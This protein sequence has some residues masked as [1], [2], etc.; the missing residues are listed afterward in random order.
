VARF[1]PRLPYPRRRC[2]SS[3]HA[4]R[5]RGAGTP[6]TPRRRDRP[7]AFG[8]RERARPRGGTSSRCRG[9]VALPVARAGPR[10]VRTRH[11]A[12]ARRRPA[13][14]RASPARRS[15]RRRHSRRFVLVQQ[16]ETHVRYA[17][18]SDGPICS[19]IPGVVVLDT[20]QVLDTPREPDRA[21]A[22]A[23]LEHSVPGA[24]HRVE[25]PDGISCQPRIFGCEALLNQDPEA[26]GDVSWRYVSEW[27]Q[28]RLRCPAEPL[29]PSRRS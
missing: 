10:L 28:S 15:S 27:S 25:E 11:E 3:R 20:G 4:S 5:Q 23:P 6:S 1:A 19:P 18:R 22:R 12:L 29:Y 13:R 16:Q 26:A 24:Q 9:R 17:G 14:S 8:S 2:S 7:C 21:A